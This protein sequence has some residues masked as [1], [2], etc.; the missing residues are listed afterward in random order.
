MPALQ[1]AA[2]QELARQIVKE[3]GLQAEDQ[4]ESRE[5]KEREERAN[6]FSRQVEVMR[7]SWDTQFEITKQWI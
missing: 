1:Q 5:L 2:L 4:Q 3:A 7:T 6:L